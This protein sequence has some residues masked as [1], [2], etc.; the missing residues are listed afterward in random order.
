VSFFLGSGGNRRL[1]PSVIQM[2]AGNE[3]RLRQGFA[4]GKTLVRRKRAAGRMAG[5][6]RLWMVLR[7]PGTPWEIELLGRSE[8]ALRR[9]APG[10]S[11]RRAARHL[12]Y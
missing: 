10:T 3:F 6:V 7:L 4:R 12:L 8:F 11:P 1:H 9:R 5:R 2:L